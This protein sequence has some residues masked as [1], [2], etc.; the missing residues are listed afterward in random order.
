[1]KPKIIR[2]DELKEKDFGHT[3]VVD[4]LQDKEWKFSIAKVFKVGSDMKTGYDKES[5]T[6]YF[7][8]DGEGTSVIDGKEYHV[9]TGDC[10]LI[11]NGTKYKNLKGLTLLAISSPPFDR[12]ERVYVE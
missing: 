5:D 7:I 9:K 3:K 12:A 1:M 2:S 6:A 10:I 8:L 4:I 11:P